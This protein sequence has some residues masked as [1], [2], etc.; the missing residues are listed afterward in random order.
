MMN[1][2]NNCGLLGAPRSFPSYSVILEA[3]LS[4]LI[5][6]KI[7]NISHQI[8]RKRIIEPVSPNLSFF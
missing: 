2:F 6:N 7:N 5:G 8:I 4:I 3:L 1:F